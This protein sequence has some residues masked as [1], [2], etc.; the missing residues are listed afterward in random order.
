MNL[1]ER[2]KKEICINCNNPNCSNDI[3][4][5]KYQ[6]VSA[7]QISTTTVVKCNGFMAKNKRESKPLNFG[8][9]IYVKKMD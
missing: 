9:N 1:I 6:E 4:E 2:Y 3:K 8:G 7:E 5:T